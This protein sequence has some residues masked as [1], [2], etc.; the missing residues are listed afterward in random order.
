MKGQS[1][2]EYA[3]IIGAILVI[4]IPIFYYT[5]HESSRTFK[6]NQA[7]DTVNTLARKADS[8]AA[9]GPGTRD[10][11]W[12]SVPGGVRSTLVANQT[13]SLFLSAGGDISAFTKTNITGTL[14][15]DP[16]TYRM[17]VETF[18]NYVF[19]GQIND[20]S[21]PQVVTSLPAGIVRITNPI[22]SATTNEAATCKYSTSDQNYDLMPNTFSGS[23]I[24]HTVQFTSQTEGGYAFYVRCRDRSDNTMQTSTLINYTITLDNTAPTVTT[25]RVSDTSVSA[26]TSICVNATVSDSSLSKVWALFSYPLNYPYSPTQNY[27][28]DDTGVS[29]SGSS[30][31][32]VY[33]ALIPMQVI[34]TIFLNTT[35]ANDSAGNI[36]YETPFPLIAINVTS[37]LYGGP[38][39]GFTYVVVDKAHYWRTPGTLLNYSDAQMSNFEEDTIDLTD[40]DKNTPPSADRFRW[41]AGNYEGFS[42]QLN[43]TPGSLNYITLRIKTVDADVLPYNLTI[44]SYTS[45]LSN[46]SL[47]NYTSFYV[48]QVASSGTNRGFNEIDITSTVHSQLNN[49]FIRIRVIPNGTSMLNRVMHI[50]EADF[51]IA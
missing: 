34:G 21:A 7:V 43:R 10:Y 23:G 9:L 31:D 3:I 2:L 47:Q 22:L 13:I 5:F 33:G 30:G 38:G 36:G 49:P 12:I 35:F 14:P 18:D 15:P 32:N 19:I 48:T 51:G 37:T 1:S 17:V 20:T 40:D 41:A 24:A 39:Q 44:Y 42:F 29:C 11:V 6:S 26:G 27:T 45:D 4:T 8:L 16:G 25:T 28:L 46:I 50:S